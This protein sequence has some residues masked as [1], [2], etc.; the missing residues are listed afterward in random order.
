MKNVNAKNVLELKHNNSPTI[1][2]ISI[3]EQTATTLSSSVNNK[4]NS[5]NKK[6]QISLQMKPK[7][8]L[9]NRLQTMI[10]LKQQSNKH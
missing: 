4:I 5:E 8:V 9:V 2:T 3:N 10:E 1:E 7:L 6:P